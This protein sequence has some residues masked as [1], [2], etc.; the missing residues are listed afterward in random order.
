LR[1][2]EAEGQA[3]KSAAR[4]RRK[5]RKVKRGRLSRKEEG[6]GREYGCKKLAVPSGGAAGQAEQGGGRAARGRKAG[7]AGEAETE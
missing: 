4:S 5:Y 7:G 2:Q 1:K 6:Q 3:G